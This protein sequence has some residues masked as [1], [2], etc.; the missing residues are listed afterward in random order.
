MIENA[1]M[2]SFPDRSFDAIFSVHSLHHFKK[3]FRVIDELMRTVS[4]EGK[5]V[6]NDFSKEG[7]V[8]IDKIHMREG[9]KHT[10]G[11]S[12]IADIKNYLL[13]KSFKVEA[14]CDRFEELI[15]A[16]HPII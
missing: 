14:H 15:V 7:F 5:I 13:E 2:L 16:Y 12:N 10:V 1:E 11:R 8:L 6:I 4:F 3:P 9:R